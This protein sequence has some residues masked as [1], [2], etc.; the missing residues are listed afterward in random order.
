MS[1][2]PELICVILITVSCHGAPPVAPAC[3]AAI[4]S[5]WFVPHHELATSDRAINHVNQAANNIISADFVPT[6]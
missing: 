2:R 4:G 3:P 5:N 6:R 1:A